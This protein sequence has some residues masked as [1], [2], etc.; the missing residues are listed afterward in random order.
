LVSDL[1]CGLA[2]MRAAMLRLPLSS[3]ILV[4]PLLAGEGLSV[5]PLIAVA[6]AIVDIARSAP[7]V[8]TGSP[9]VAN[10]AQASTL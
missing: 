7:A 5:D 8:A 6:V 1:A 10:Q 3:A 2:G 4:G 9:A